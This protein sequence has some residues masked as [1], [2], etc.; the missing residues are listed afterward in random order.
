MIRETITAVFAPFHC[1]SATT[2]TPLTRL[3]ALG[4][5]TVEKLTALQ[6]ASLSRYHALAFQYVA[7]TPR[8]SDLRAAPS[9][10]EKHGA[11][12]RDV[13]RCSVHDAQAIGRLWLE[14]AFEAIRLLGDRE[15]QAPARGPR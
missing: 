10:W 15:L 14:V 2:L 8:V 13:G 7:T 6:L 4:I 5:D 12:L 11:V 1:P 3:T 9:F